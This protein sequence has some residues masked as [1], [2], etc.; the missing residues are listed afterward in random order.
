MTTQRLAALLGATATA[1]L[2]SSLTVTAYAAIGGPPCQSNA[3]CSDRV[4]MCEKAAGRCTDLE[5]KGACIKRPEICT[6]DFKPVCGCDGKTY[7]NDCHRQ[8]A[9]VTL[10][11][12][13]E[14][15]KAK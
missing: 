5:A 13:G 12:A 11:Y 1:V 10:N 3:D 4:E 8:S 6:E 15:K 2:L 9:G 7:S 14:C